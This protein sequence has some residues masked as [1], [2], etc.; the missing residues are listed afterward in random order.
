MN[1]FEYVEEFILTEVGIK[2]TDYVGDETDVEIPSEINGKPVLS[3]GKCAFINKNVVNVKISDTVLI[4][5]DGAF[6]GCKQLETITLS[7]NLLMILKKA[8]SYCGNLKEITIPNG[9]IELFPCTFESCKKL[10]K[11]T[12]LGLQYI[13]SSAF[14]F[15]NSLQELF[16]STEFKMMDTLFTEL[17][18]K[19]RSQDT[20]KITVFN[21]PK[22]GPRNEYDRF[23]RDVDDYGFCIKSNR[24]SSYLLFNGLTAM[25]KTILLYEVYKGVLDETLELEDTS[26]IIFIGHKLLGLQ[27]EYGKYKKGQR[28]VKWL[29]NGE[30]IELVFNHHFC[31]SQNLRIMDGLYFCQ[32]FPHFFENW[33]EYDSDEKSFLKKI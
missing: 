14:T 6:Y 20:V 28:Y 11:V 5:E 3:I 10:Q 8:F 16:V 32:I 12:A 21:S 1:K 31:K 13:D 30:M 27:Y 22:I 23:R 33:K 7:E 2:I 4:I 29:S 17:E 26:P 9:V 19:Y 18:S 24:G 15:C 25:M